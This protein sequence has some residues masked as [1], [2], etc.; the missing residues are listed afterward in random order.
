MSEQPT[1]QQNDPTWAEYLQRG[2]QMRNMPAEAPTMADAAHRLEAST[3]P[4]DAVVWTPEDIRR[5]DV[6]LAK[7]YGWPEPPTV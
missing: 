7:I 2:Q 3:G 1:S 4:N 5:L 6:A